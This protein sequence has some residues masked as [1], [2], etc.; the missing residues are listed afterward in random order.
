VLA[1]IIREERNILK[2]L[3]TV[4]GKLAIQIFERN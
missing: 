3:P 4:R 2:L 1:C